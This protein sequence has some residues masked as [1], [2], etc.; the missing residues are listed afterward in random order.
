MKIYKANKRGFVIYL[1]LGT[2]LLAVAVFLLDIKTFSE[3]PFILLPLFGPAALLGWIYF[4]TYYIVENDCLRYKSAFMRGEVDILSIREI[5][6]G[7]TMWSGIKPALAGNGLII[8]YNR[9]DELYLAP[10]S[11]S[12]LI[13]D[14][15]KINV[16]I[17]VTDWKRVHTNSLG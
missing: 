7:K 2:L 9:Y 4:D 13:A 3:K 12:E 1:L 10:E 11:N 17:K 15:L 8:K 6:V 5:I 16:N 14:L